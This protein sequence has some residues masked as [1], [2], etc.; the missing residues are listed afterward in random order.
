VREKEKEGSRERELKEKK[1]YLGIEIEREREER[2][3][4]REIERKNFEVDILLTYF[5][6]QNKLENF[7]PKQKK[8]M[9]VVLKEKYSFLFLSNLSANFLLLK[10]CNRFNKDFRNCKLIVTVC[11]FPFSTSQW[12]DLNP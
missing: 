6:R 11:F 4:E 1:K 7:W 2:E 10:L 12:V 9:K 3:R 8:M 5:R